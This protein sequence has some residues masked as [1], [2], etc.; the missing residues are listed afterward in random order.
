MA[1]LRMYVSCKKAL[2]QV[3]EYTAD[4]VHFEPPGIAGRAVP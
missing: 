1:I 3:K 2:S 4:T